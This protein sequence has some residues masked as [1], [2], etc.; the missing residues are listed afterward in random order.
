[1][2]SRHFDV[3]QP[4]HTVRGSH[5]Q[6]TVE[7]M[8]SQQKVESDGNVQ[9]QTF[10]KHNTTLTHTSAVASICFAVGAVQQSNTLLLHTGG[11][12]TVIYT[13]TKG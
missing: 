9:H 3:R 12:L 8:K 6:E 13:L 11:E 1:M 10:S 7:G 2:H 4:C 5:G